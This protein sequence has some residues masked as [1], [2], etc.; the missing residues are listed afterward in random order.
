MLMALIN[1]D[2]RLRPIVIGNTLKRVA[3]KIR[4]KQNP[5]SDEDILKQVGCGIKPGTEIAVLKLIE[6][7]DNPKC[8]A[9]SKVEFK[10]HLTSN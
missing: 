3:S 8:T 10:L 5:L 7:N 1:I 2:K 4:W 9:L 6:R